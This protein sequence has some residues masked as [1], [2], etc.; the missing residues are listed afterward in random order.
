MAQFRQIIMPSGNH[1]DRLRASTPI[2]GKKKSEIRKTKEQ[3]DGGMSL[4]FC[5]PTHFPK[6]VKVPDSIH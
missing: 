6:L 5:L 4:S 1:C 3:R 2:K